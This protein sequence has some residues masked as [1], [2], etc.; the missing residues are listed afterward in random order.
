MGLLP[1]FQAFQKKAWDRLELTEAQQRMYTAERL[2]NFRW[3]AKLVAA[4]STYELKEEDVV[5]ADLVLW[6][7]E[8]G[9]IGQTSSQSSAGTET[10]QVNSQK[11]SMRLLPY[12]LS[13]RA[14]TR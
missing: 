2:E 1:L 14:T 7:R 6:L 4:Y 13:L 5:A 8:I 3:I 11:S 9:E 12:T 10:Q